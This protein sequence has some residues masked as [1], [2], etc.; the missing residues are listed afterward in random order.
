MRVFV[1][2]VLVLS[3]TLLATTSFAE[4]E[5]MKVL[6]RM[7]IAAKQLSY[8]GVFAYQTGKNLQ[9][10]R[11]IHRADEQGEVERLVSLNGS[12]REVIRTNDLVTCIFPEGKRIQV[13][14]RPL[15]RGFPS[16][17][18]RRL[19]SATPYYDVVTG[20]DGRVADRKASELII[21][22][23]DNYRYGFRLWV[24]KKSDL[25]LKSELL[26]ENGIVLE[27]FSFSMVELNKT[28]PD[29]LLQP[30]ISGKEMTW[31]RTEPET[32]INM[33]SKQNFSKW[34]IAWLPEGFAL[35]A[36]QNRLKA[37]NGAS[38]EQRVYSD[39]LS[40]VSVFIEKIRAR[41]SH[42]HGGS[43]MGAVNAFG[44]I[45]SAHFVTVVGEVPAKTVEKMGASISYKGDSG[46]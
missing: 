20:Q 28:I 5:A 7:G 13:N 17:L 29:S 27:T 31:N 33:A 46:Q 34:Q 42:L 11:I 14:R 36:Q 18:L 45:L 19:S 37:N 22:P 8:E 1:Q 24:D 43:K 4:P 3:L 40:S 44:T 9:S 16:D 26:A 6:E 41:H 2:L 21:K 10:I 30:Q 25:L 32:G 39:G 38:V 23:I 15:G 12:A 35:V